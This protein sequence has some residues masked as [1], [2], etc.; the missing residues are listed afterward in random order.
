MS[1]PVQP[2]EEQA[3]QR[4]VVRYVRHHG[5][6]HPA[7]LGEAETNGVLT[8]LAVRGKVA[9]S[10][11]NQAL[12]ALQFLSRHVLLWRGRRGRRVGRGGARAGRGVCR[13]CCRATRF[14]WCLAG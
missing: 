6:R 14:G 10:T 5:M 2:P 4:R 13:W 3:Y 1:A 8:H 7:D 9:A 12:A 11:Q